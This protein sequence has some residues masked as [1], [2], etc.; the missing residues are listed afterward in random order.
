MDSAQ[1][2]I[3]AQNSAARARAWRDAHTRGHQ[4][5]TQ[6]ETLDLVRDL[7]ALVD[8]IREIAGVV[9]TQRP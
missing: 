4:P 6:R 7:G 9:A 8:A 2:G 3:K 5:L 1:D